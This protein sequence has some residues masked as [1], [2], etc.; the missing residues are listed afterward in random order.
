MPKHKVLAF[1]SMV[2]IVALMAITGSNAVSVS[3][4]DSTP[5]AT[6]EITAELKS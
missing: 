5:A 1:V 2:L 6:A 4:Q 3:A